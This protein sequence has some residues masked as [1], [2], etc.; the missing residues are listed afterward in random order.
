MVILFYSL[1][2]VESVVKTVPPPPGQGVGSMGRGPYVAVVIIDSDHGRR[3]SQHCHHRRSVVVKSTSTVVIIVVSSSSLSE[4]MRLRASSLPSKAGVV[5]V[6]HRQQ[7]NP[8]RGVSQLSCGGQLS[9]RRVD[10]GRSLRG[11]CGRCGRCACQ[12]AAGRAAGRSQWVCINWK[13]TAMEA[14]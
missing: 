2:G 7:R 4:I 1:L 13:D 14:I 6:R 10:R 5:I 9:K 11:R 12:V 8:G 3:W